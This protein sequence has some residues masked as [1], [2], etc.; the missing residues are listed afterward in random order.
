MFYSEYDEAVSVAV[1]NAV[2]HS[3]SKTIVQRF[4]MHVHVG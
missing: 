2:S 1:V 4:D 3:R